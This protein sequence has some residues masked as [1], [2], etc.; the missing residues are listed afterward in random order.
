MITILSQ[1]KAGPWKRD[2]EKTKTAF[3]DRFQPSAGPGNNDLW[4]LRTCLANETYFDLREDGYY[5]LLNPSP[6][7]R[8]FPC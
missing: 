7:F 2:F 3:Y 6:A 8:F 4:L 1:R 5:D